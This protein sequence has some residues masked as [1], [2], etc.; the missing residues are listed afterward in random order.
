MKKLATVCLALLFAGTLSAQT[1]SGTG[2][3][4]VSSEVDPITDT[5]TVTFLLPSDSGVSTYGDKIY[6]IIRH[7]PEHHDE[8]FINWSSYLSDE[9]QVVTFRMGNGLPDTQQWSRSTNNEST[10]HYWSGISSI[11]QI[12]YRLTIVDRVAARTTPYNENPITA[13]FDVRGLANAAEP[14]KDQLEWLNSPLPEWQ[15]DPITP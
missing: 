1:F 8:L 14:F 2:K 12:L 13:I 9:R 3:W 4:K 15:P 10:F 11:E 7:S 6:L 5:A